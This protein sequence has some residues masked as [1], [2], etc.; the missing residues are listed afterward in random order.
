MRVCRG[1]GR[2]SSRHRQVMEFW[3]PLTIAAAFF[4]NVRSVLQKRLQ[5]SLGTRGATYVR[6]AY[7]LPVALAYLG[8]LKLR[9][10]PFPV[11]HTSFLLYTFV[12]GTLQILATVA[13]LTSFRTRNFAAGVAYSKTEPVQAAFFGLV[14]LGDIM[15]PLGFLAIVL[16]L[17]AVLTLTIGADVGRPAFWSRGLRDRAA[18]FGILSGAGFGLA[19]VLYRG[20]ALSLEHGDFILR[21]AVTLACVLTFQ[22]I[23]MTLEMLL[24]ERETFRPVCTH[25]RRGAMVGAI[26]VSASACWFA[27]GVLQQAA[28]VRALGQIELVFATLSSILVFQERL[29]RREIVGMLL[30]VLAIVVLVLA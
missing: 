4:Q 2:R 26:G 13:L 16:G 3:I 20:A 22:T 9:G 21:S 14:I 6:F 15:A 12:G 5:Q 17:V 10:D 30:L 7:G 29:E 19:A 27:A 1:E 8:A 24:V 23:V 25:W 28:Y 18:L 11:L